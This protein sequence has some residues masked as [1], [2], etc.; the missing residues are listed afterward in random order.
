LNDQQEY[1]PASPSRSHSPSPSLS[2][3]QSTRPTSAYK[4]GNVI[5]PSSSTRAPSFTSMGMSMGLGKTGMHI[6]SGGGSGSFR[7]YQSSKEISP[8]AR[9]RLLLL[10]SQGEEVPMYSNSFDRSIP[11]KALQDFSSDHRFNITK[12]ASLSPDRQPGA[13]MDLDHDSYA[14]TDFKESNNQLGTSKIG[15]LMYLTSFQ[16]SVTTFFCSQRLREKIH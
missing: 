5:S 2:F 11:E 14:L 8:A 16:Y 15:I 1:P 7:F 6:S 12:F 13:G 10:R 3:M 4:L 9:R